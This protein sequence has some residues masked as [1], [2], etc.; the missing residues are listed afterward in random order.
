MITYTVKGKTDGFGSQYQSILSGIAYCAYKN[1]VYIH[2]P[3][4]TLDHNGDL[5]RANE[6]MGINSY[7]SSI[8]CNIVVP[9]EQI[10]HYSETPSIYYTDAV[11]E[12]IRTQ[13]FKNKKP[14]I[15]IPDIAIHIRR[16][17]VTKNKNTERYTDN[18]YYKE[19]IKKI[20]IKYPTYTITIFSEGKY[21][22]FIELGLKEKH[23]RLNTDLFETFHSLV[24]AKVL[25]QSFS[26]FSYCAG[27]INKNTVYHYD[28]FW[29]KKLDLYEMKIH[30]YFHSLLI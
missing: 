12:F 10:V 16:G 17:D 19:L 22:D 21:E 4:T 24:C 1:Y 28:D 20:K 18:N 29:H 8:K 7:N 25:I 13:Y 15:E 14:Q 9:Y 26:S 6:F 3:L 27:L 2:T 11:L 5:G 30:N 23:F